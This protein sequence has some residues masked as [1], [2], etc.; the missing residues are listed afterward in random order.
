MPSGL[1]TS[2]RWRWLLPVALGAGLFHLLPIRD[3]VDRAFFDA[4]SRHPLRTTLPPEG[5]AL[6]LM[7]DATLAA[8]S[9]NGFGGTWPPPRG[10]FAALIAGLHRAG[11]A[12]I[13]VDFVFLDHST[14]VEQDRLLG[15][16]A[17]GVPSVVLAR[18]RR[19]MPAFW[20]EKFVAT[21]AALFAQ[22]RTGHADA[23]PEDPDGVLR[24][25]RAPGSLAATAAPQPAG[26][27]EGLLRWYGGLETVR[28]L[29]PRVP[30]ISAA[31]FVVN[32]L[33][34]AGRLAETSPDGNYTP[35]SL[36]AALAQEV[37]LRGATFDAVRG[38]TVFVGASATGTFDQKPFPIG[39]LEPGVLVHWTAWANLAGN[40]FIRRLPAFTS[41]LI[42]LA[43]IATLA[44][45]SLRRPGILVPVVVAG[46][47]AAE[48]LIILSNVPGLLRQFPDE[49]TL[50]R[51]I[52]KDKVEASLEFAE[53]R[54]KKKVLGASEA[55][56]LG[57]QKVVFADGRC[58]SPIQKA[59]NGEGTVIS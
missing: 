37:P 28:T 16:L 34:T 13:V 20:D 23:V 57:V 52:D 8:L 44:L 59:L 47:V 11:A 39:K 36:A 15:A 22:P 48:Q 29:G 2:L 5:S 56:A 46:A 43:G 7:D 25:Y 54:M 58:E 41:P 33:P 3:A 40:G 38:R 6:V 19:Q 18:T 51:H 50:I 17:A 14:A 9:E 55:T 32:G 27:E 45:L 53:G 31:S 30:V 21:H 35:A 4:A 26:P 42:A 10:M 1:A 12:K 49:S 24:R